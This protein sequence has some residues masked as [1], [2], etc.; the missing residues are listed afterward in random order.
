MEDKILEAIYHVKSKANRNLSIKKIL[1]HIWKSTAS[2]FELRDNRGNHIWYGRI[3]GPDED[4]V[5]LFV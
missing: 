1:S 4:V 5:K 2:N 3:C